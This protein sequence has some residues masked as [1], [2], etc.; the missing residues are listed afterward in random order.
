MVLFAIL[1]RIQNKWLKLFIAS[2]IFV[3]ISLTWP[4]GLNDYFEYYYLPFF[5]GYFMAEWQ[6]M[7]HLGGWS[8]PIL[9]LVACSMTQ[10]VPNSGW[11]ALNHLFGF[12]NGGLYRTSIALLVLVIIKIIKPPLVGRIAKYSLTAYLLEPIISYLISSRLFGIP[13]P[14]DVSGEIYP[15]FI[16]LRIVSTLL[17]AWTICFITTKI[18]WKI[19]NIY[20]TKPITKNFEI[21]LL[22]NLIKEVK[23]S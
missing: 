8:I 20:T 7:E 16:I 15:V 14:N 12:M 1:H 11:A 23:K 19:K 6:L 3:G 17:L 2:F 4:N 13:F 9:A 5:V 21:N 22:P 18:T 10:A